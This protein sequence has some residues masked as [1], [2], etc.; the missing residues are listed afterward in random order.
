MKKHYVSKSH[1]ELQKKL[2]YTPPDE[3]AKLPQGK[4]WEQLLR[5]GK[6]KE[7]YKLWFESNPN[8]GIG[9]VHPGFWAN[10]EIEWAA[11]K[12]AVLKYKAKD[13]IPDYI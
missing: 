7:A 12:E 2:G 13:T 5:E 8:V 10:R 6:E 9:Y 3:L 1:K 4:S 11:D